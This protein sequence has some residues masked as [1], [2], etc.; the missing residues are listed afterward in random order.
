MG[1]TVFK[2]PASLALAALTA[3]ALPFSAGMGE[4]IRPL[5]ASAA[6]AQEADEGSAWNLEEMETELYAG[7]DWSGAAGTEKSP[8]RKPQ[9]QQAVLDGMM[10]GECNTSSW[11]CQNL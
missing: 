11:A 7:T 3:L 6:V 9:F 2:R 4:F 10:Y 5:T 1:K 8:A